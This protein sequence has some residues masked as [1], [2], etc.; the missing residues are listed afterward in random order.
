M[1]KKLKFRHKLLVLALT[2]LVFLL[3]FFIFTRSSNS[4]PDEIIFPTGYIRAENHAD[5]GIYLM[6]IEHPDFY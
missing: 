5:Y 1:P 6:F 3:S 4:S 2:G